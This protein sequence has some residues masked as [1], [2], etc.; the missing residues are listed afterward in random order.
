MPLQSQKESCYGMEVDRNGV[1]PEISLARKALP[2]Q[3]STFRSVVGPAD[4]YQ[5][6]KAGSDHSQSS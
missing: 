5:G 2:L 1:F 6:H 4:L 3:L